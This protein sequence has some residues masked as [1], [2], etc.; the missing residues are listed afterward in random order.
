MSVSILS[1]LA[2]AIFAT[3]MLSGVFGMAGGMV[4]M[5]ILLA[6]L[7]VQIAMTLHAS[8]QLIANGWRC[9]LWRKHIVWRVIPP[10]AAGMVAGV[11]LISLIHYVPS[12]PAA[13]IVLGSIPLLAMAAS[14][15]VHI[16]VMNKPQTFIT[17]T[18]LTFVQM[19]AGVIGPLLDLLY[20]NTNMTRHQIISTKAF[21]QSSMHLVRLIY[22][23]AMM[24]L[25]SG[26]S[27]WPAGLSA[28]MM[29]VFAAC[30][31]AGTSS[32]AFVL[33][34]I[35]DQTFKQASRILIFC[36]SLYCLGN[37][38]YLLMGPQGL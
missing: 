35:S 21:T 17:A 36:I 8:V 32:A 19:T 12:K 27:S 16:S 22:F 3:A 25:I 31:I 14:R 33:H 4:L 1:L 9:F 20:N 37:G 26:T 30:S 5:V 2:L 11:A 34:K 18:V 15:R 28:T 24:P 29:L 23:G 6:F 7:P 10:Y 13:L 38:L